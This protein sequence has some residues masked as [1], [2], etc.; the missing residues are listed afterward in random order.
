[1]RIIRDYQFVD[2]A[3]RGAAAAIIST[4]TRNSGRV[5]PETIIRVE[6]GG[7]ASSSRVM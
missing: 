7:A 3:D 6:A 4:S 1:M 5:K 2:A